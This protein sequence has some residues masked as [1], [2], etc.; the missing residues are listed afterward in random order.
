MPVL[1]WIGKDKV[2]NHDKDLPYRVLKPVKELSV[3]EGDKNLLIEGDNLEALKALM[4][5]YYNQVKCIY[6]DPPYNTG[7][8]KW[9]YND[10]VNSPHIKK[11]L[12][13]VVKIDDLER[14]DKWL[15]MMYP[16][17]K[18]LHQ[19]LSDNGVIFISIDDNEVHNLKLILNDIFDDKNFITQFCWRKTDNQANIGNV[20]NVKEYIICFAKDKS[21]LSF[22][23]VE[24]SEKA[25]R[26]Y[27][28]KDK[29]GFFRRRNI[30]DKSRGKKNYSITAPNGTV[31]N[32]PWMINKDEFEK[33]NEQGLIYWAS[34]KM[35]YGKKYLEEESGQIISDLLGIEFGT[36]QQASV[37]LK[38]IFNKRVFDFPKP[39][40]LIK[41]LVQ[42]STIY[43]DFVLDSF[44]GTGTTCHSV[45][46]LNK[47]DGGKRQFILVELE[48][49]IAQKI[50]KK[51][52]EAV[53]KGYKD[54][55]HEHGTGQSFQYLQLNGQ[56][57]SNNGFINADAK[58]DDLA[59]YIYFTENR[60][61]LDLTSIKKPYIGSISSNHY[62]LFF[63]G[64]GK[65]I[66][67][68]K[69]IMKT[70]GYKGTKVIYAD[71]CLLDEEYL[72]ANKIIFKQ[73][74]YELKKF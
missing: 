64:Q 10:K 35:P 8:E 69:S 71:K 65:N 74:P 11:W 70:D 52:L 2:E 39:H 25:K 30:L 15:C 72:E 50:T 7:N 54:A 21:R 27:R 51:R 55:L 16:R 40:T 26:E 18:L 48:N 3:G 56:L 59:G 57:Y 73:I 29:K 37:E 32:G 23:K 5:F 58:Y 22:S 47:T 28:Y 33:L 17:L 24:L 13:S 38:K 63:E 60:S 61:Y 31:L 42:M 6:I 53:I 1:N 12:N 36:N 9:A 20:A 14:H 34:N 68:E 66:L 67:D 43:D 62:F 45:L 44:A 19:L 4:P 46:E 49:N 41:A